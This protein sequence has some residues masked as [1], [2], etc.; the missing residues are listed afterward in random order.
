M[1]YSNSKSLY[2]DFRKGKMSRL[3]FLKIFGI[4]LIGE[5][6]SDVS[7]QMIGKFFSVKQKEQS[8][9]LYE[10]ELIDRLFKNYRTNAKFIPGTAHR[11]HT[12]K[13]HPDD[14]VAVKSL[15]KIGISGIDKLELVNDF[16]R[17]PRIDGNLLVL[18][19]PSTN[20]LTTLTFQYNPNPAGQSFGFCRQEDPQFELPF[21][22]FMD[23]Q[24][25][26]EQGAVYKRKVIGTF[27]EGPNWGIRNNSNGDIILPN[28]DSDGLITNDYLLV[29]VLPNIYDVAGN[30]DSRL[31]FFGGAH[32][33]GTKAIDLLFQNKKLLESLVT[34]TEKTPYWQALIEVKQIF[35]DPNTLISSPFELD[36]N[37]I[38]NPIKLPLSEF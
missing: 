1:D 32:G 14:L 38:I 23:G 12:G 26:V 31:V 6:L 19:S 3:D 33:T 8:S 37:P 13:I 5:T 2:D 16:I 21:D 34:K 9:K 17:P 25:L 30:T 36:M 29:T 28:V 35:H 10:I 22:F 20:A 24:Y 27:K 4:V 11:I 7:G 18:G 15:E